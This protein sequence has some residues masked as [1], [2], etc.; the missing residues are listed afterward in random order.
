MDG[1]GFVDLQPPVGWLG[2]C[3]V[4]VWVRDR[5]QTADDTFW[6]NVMPVRARVFLPLVLNNRP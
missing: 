3:D 1:G 6:V 4:G 5:L 2:R